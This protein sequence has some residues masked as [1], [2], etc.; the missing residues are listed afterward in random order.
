MEESNTSDHMVKA[1]D[2]KMANS[3]IKYFFGVGMLSY[4]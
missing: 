4:G 3:I 2:F 1:S